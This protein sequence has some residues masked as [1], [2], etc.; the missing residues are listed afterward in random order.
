M[1]INPAPVRPVTNMR[2]FIFDVALTSYQLVPRIL[3]ADKDAIAAKD[4][5]DDAYFEKFFAGIRP[6]L[7]QQL[8]GAI[9]ATSSAIVS[10]WTQAGK[11][12]PKAA[13]PRPVEKV[14]K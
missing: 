3:A 14:R 11:P 9:T 12:V 7:E 8:S 1:A 2:D 10:A 6:V 4:V 13:V 5:Y